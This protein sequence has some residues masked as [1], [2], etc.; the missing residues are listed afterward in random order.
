M[1][2]KPG[3]SFDLTRVLAENDETWVDELILNKETIYT[4]P[5]V[6]GPVNMEGKWLLPN[7][8]LWA[9]LIRRD[10]PVRMEHFYRDEPFTDGVQIRIHT[11]VYRDVLALRPNTTASIREEMARS[12]NKLYNIIAT[13]FGAEQRTLDMFSIVESME[14]P[15]IAS[16][17]FLHFGPNELGSITVAEEKIRD[18]SERM[19]RILSDPRYKDINVLYPFV[20]C[21]A[22]SAHQ[23]PQVLL[24]A[25]TRTDVNDMM[26]YKAIRSSY[27]RGLGN[28]VEAAIDSLAAKKALLYNKG[29]LGITRYKDRKQQLLS[30]SLSHIYPGD[31]GT[32]VTVP[33][34][35]TA[36]N[37][38]PSI[39]KFIM[40]NGQLDELLP[41]NVK[42]YIGKEVHLRSPLGCR[43]V[44]GCCRICGG[45]MIDYLLPNT[46]LGLAATIELMSPTAQLILSSRHFSRTISLAYTPTPMYEEMFAVERNAIAFKP[47]LPVSRYR[48]GIPFAYASRI[49]DLQYV[50][51]GEA[52]NDQH[53]S[54]VELMTVAD[55]ATGKPVVPLASLIDVNGS[56]PYL[57]SEVLLYIK[58]NPTM[59]IE[60]GSTLWIDL[61]HFDATQPIMRSIVVNASMV[62]FTKRIHALFS[63]TITK[64]TSASAVLRDFS[65]IV[66]EKLNTNLLHLEVIIRSSMIT[67][68]NDYR[69]PQVSDIHN[70][71]FGTLNALMRQRSIGAQL[72]YER[73]DTYL[74]DARTYTVPKPSGPFDALAGFGI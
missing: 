10:L 1:S 62:R 50:T 44:D 6:E 29:S 41:E 17:C 55:T 15:I 43:Y 64:Y 67:S 33:F 28:I 59:L 60:A 14:H 72:A 61:K 16:A 71:Q 42:S 31:C 9:P 63:K 36:V 69:I 48:I 46:V 52:I 37:A 8:L 30:S 68:A 40:V 24:A 21:G 70:V 11:A 12:I 20:K 32:T 45:R 66:Y 49:S 2:K 5:M 22:V 39:G 13:R 47:G 7:V 54:S 65:N 34:Q 58:N 19:M 38:K 73:M 3:L 26:I 51:T 74:E 23:L 4:I 57:S 25:G 18:G 35:I 56:V 53:F 27:V